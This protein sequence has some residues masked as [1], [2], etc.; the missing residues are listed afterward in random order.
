[1]SELQQPQKKRFKVLSNK[2]L[3]QK[4]INQQ[5]E[6][7]VNSEKRADKA[8]KHFLTESGCDS[9]EYYFFEEK[10]LCDWLSKFWFRARTIPD[11][12]NEEGEFYSVNTLR[13]FK[14]ALN[15]ILK[16]HGHEFDITK[17]PNFKCAM[18]AFDN[19]VKELKEH[20]KGHVKSAE[21]IT[22]DG[23]YCIVLF[24]VR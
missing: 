23:K 17:S 10:E 20:G 7:T 15:R 11:K 13:N 4:I 6:N 24:L 18:D 5:N 8:F 1:M 2:D 21:E 3:K 22:E 14:Y 9:N 19:A 16:K 12:E